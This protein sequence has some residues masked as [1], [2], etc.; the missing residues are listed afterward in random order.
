MAIHGAFL[1]VRE[2]RTLVNAKASM[3]KRAQRRMTPQRELLMGE[4]P[5]ADL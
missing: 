1:G 2:A 5:G 3:L 4:G